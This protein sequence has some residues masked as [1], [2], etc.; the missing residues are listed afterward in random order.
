MVTYFVSSFHQ[1]LGIHCET[2]TPTRVEF[3]CAIVGEYSTA[4]QAIVGCHLNFSLLDS[5]AKSR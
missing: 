3:E 1:L 2:A 5:K 4:F